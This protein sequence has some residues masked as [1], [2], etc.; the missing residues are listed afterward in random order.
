MFK[1]LFT[2]FNYLRIWH[3]E[4]F[5]FDFILPFILTILFGVINFNLYHKI[6]FLGNSGLVSVINGILQILSGFFIAALAA[7][8]TASLEKLDEPMKGS[9]PTYCGDKNRVITRRLFLTHLF[10]YLAFMSIMVYL[11]GGVAQLLL[12]TIKSFYETNYYGNLKLLISSIYL[13][14]VFQVFSIT[15]LGL[16]F[17]IEDNINKARSKN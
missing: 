14:F 8:A 6:S 17:L 12:E 10:G 9:K 4:K 2:P 13:F 5:M 7:I 16:F 3:K 1:K 15:I 11:T